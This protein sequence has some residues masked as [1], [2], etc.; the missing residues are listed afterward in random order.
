MTGPVAA[1]GEGPAAAA[2]GGRHRF[3]PC[4]GT[5]AGAPGCVC[6]PLVAAGDPS[7]PLVGPRV[8]MEVGIEDCLHIEFEYDKAKYH[9]RVR[10]AWGRKRER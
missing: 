9:L 4:R 1:P 8:Q 10:G 3:H 6:D 7:W 2:A 5:A